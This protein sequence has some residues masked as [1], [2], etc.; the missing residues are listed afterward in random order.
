MPFDTHYPNRKD[1]RRPFRK[2]KAFDRSCRNHGGCPYCLGNRRHADARREQ[3]ARDAIVDAAIAW[4]E[5]DAHDPVERLAADLSL[6][7]ALIALRDTAPA[8]PCGPEG[9]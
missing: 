4:G 9:M 6:S 1:Q 8:A 2:S 7:M 3:A 5:S